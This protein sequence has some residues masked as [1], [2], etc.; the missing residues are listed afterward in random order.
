VGL[1]D[2]LMLAALVVAIG[3]GIMNGFHVSWGTGHELNT[4]ISM[5]ITDHG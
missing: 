1:D 4:L 2:Y 3:M 5:G